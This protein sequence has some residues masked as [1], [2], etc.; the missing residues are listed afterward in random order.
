MVHFV[1]S[2]GVQK[3]WANY[4]GSQVPGVGCRVRMVCGWQLAVSGIKRV[5]GAGSGVAGK[6]LTEL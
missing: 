6:I 5:L 3:R 1:L 4:S 2:E